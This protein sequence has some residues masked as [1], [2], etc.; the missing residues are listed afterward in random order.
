MNVHKFEYL[1]NGKT[2][3]KQLLSYLTDFVCYETSPLPFLNGQYQ[4]G[5]NTKQNQMKN[6][7]LF[8]FYSNF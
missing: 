7:C 8:T 3:D 1:E 6:T 4:D 2:V 5:Q